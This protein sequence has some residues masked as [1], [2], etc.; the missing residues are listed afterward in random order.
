MAI[1][2]ALSLGSKTRIAVTLLIDILLLAGVVFCIYL[3]LSSFGVIG[4]SDNNDSVGGS[5]NIS[6]STTT[7][8][9][10]QHTFRPNPPDSLEIHVPAKTPKDAIK[11]FYL[12][13]KH[14]RCEKAKLLRPGYTKCNNV[15]SVNLNKY[16]MEYSNNDWAI[17]YIK[18]DVLT[19]NNKYNHFEGH[20]RVDKAGN[21]WVINGKTYRSK[22]SYAEYLDFLQNK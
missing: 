14:N 16:K 6:P 17:F 3:V 11:G 21:G 1:Q 22:M 19:D 20:V 7:A 2:I 10:D 12:A 8:N 9:M 4:A 5:M 18:V 15:R 13:L